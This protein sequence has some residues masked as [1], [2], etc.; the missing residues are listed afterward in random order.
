MEN[1]TFLNRS[2]VSSN[3]IFTH[4]YFI[5]DNYIAM[6]ATRGVPWNFL[7]VTLVWWSV[8]GYEVTWERGNYTFLHR[9]HYWAHLGGFVLDAFLFYVGVE[10]MKERPWKRPQDAGIP[11]WCFT[12]VHIPFFTFFVWFYFILVPINFFTLNKLW[13]ILFHPLGICGQILC[14]VFNGMIF[15]FFLIDGLAFFLLE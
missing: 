5:P 1:I 7:I 4:S 10:C 2:W 15:P 6:Q 12:I 3:N 9:I 8:D 11:I 14:L 13:F